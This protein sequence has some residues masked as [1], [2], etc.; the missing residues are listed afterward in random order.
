MTISIPQSLFDKWKEVGNYLLENDNFSRVATL[1]FPP[2]KEACTSE[3][4][5]GGDSAN[6]FLHGGP[7]PFS[8]NECVNCGGTGFRE[9][10]VTSTVRLRTYWNK[11]NWIKTGNIAIPDAE[12]Q[13]IGKMSDLPSIRAA[14]KIHL[15]SEEKAMDLF[16]VMA[17]EAYPH[18]FGKDSFFIT[19]L[20]RT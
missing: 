8:F 7:A 9:K 20:K 6:V 18:G 15:L 13:I 2:I 19:F 11:K 3:N 5:F 14:I 1:Y 16:F 10:E 4:H 12:V 17:G